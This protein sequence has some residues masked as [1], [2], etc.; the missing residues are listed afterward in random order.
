MH[1]ERWVIVKRAHVEGP[2]YYWKH[3]MFTEHLSEARQWD[4]MMKCYQF[5]DKAL[6]PVDYG[7]FRLSDIL[8]G[9]VG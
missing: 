5:R 4:D 2:R 6:H 8:M 1:E 7:V 3:M 9:E